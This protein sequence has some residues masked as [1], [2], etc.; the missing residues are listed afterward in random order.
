MF[1]SCIQGVRVRGSEPTFLY[2]L[3]LVIWIERSLEG[4]EARG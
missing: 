3:G 2:D 4:Q 1:G